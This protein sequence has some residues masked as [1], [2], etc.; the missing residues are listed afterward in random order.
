MMNL[1]VFKERLK[2][3]YSKNDFYLI[4]IVKFL[5][6]LITLLIL[7]QHI[8]FAAPLK[9]IAI[10]LIISL[11]CSFIPMSLAVVLLAA[12]ILG[13]VMAL[14]VELGVIM[15]VMFLVMFLG[16]YR[17]AP[18]DGIVL[19]LMP[20]LFLL[21]I[22]Y[23]L[24]IIV[25]LV[26]TPVSIVSVAFG[27]I[28]YYSIAYISENT[29]VITNISSDDVLKKINVFMEGLFANRNMYVAIVAFT[30]VIVAVYVIRR[31]SIN[32]SWVIAIIA[33]SLI[34]IAVFLLGDM[35]F[36]TSESS[37]NVGMLIFGTVLSL[38]IAF[39]VNF[40]IF[41][42]DYSRTEYTQFEDDDYYYYVKAVPK[43][44]VTT[45]EVSV[46]RINARRSRR[47]RAENR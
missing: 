46:K 32:Y 41:S 9:N 18:R 10:V 43:I 15:L 44:N 27:T 13:H 6:A 30:C 33:G 35:I 23:V 19:I 5:V 3:F 25:G 4:P 34:N 21:K 22:P 8:G 26:A 29:V 38:A 36:V 47:P 24:P 28:L 2:Q 12:F 31:L 17:F 40:C 11:L 7:N 20:L 42:V 1:L 16:Y 45:P 14:S 37:L 39:V